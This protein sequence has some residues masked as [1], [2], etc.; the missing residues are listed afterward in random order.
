MLLG[1]APFTEPMVMWWNFIGRSH[2]EVEQLRSD[3]ETSS[4]CFTSFDDRIGGLIPAPELPHV[5]LK[6]R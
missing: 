4:S 2:E 6:A 5:P 1:G 3:W